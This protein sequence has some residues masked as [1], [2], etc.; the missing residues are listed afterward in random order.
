MLSLGIRILN[1]EEK[2]RT[3]LALTQQLFERIDQ[4]DS[5]LFATLQRRRDNLIHEV[6]LESSDIDDSDARLDIIRSTLT[7]TKL[8]ND[9]MASILAVREAEL[10]KEKRALSKAKKMKNAYQGH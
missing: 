3:I 8:I 4:S 1:L 7:E 9:K 2:S 10:I 6:A 5:E